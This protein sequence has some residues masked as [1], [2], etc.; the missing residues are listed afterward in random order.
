[1]LFDIF[2]LRG[3]SINHNFV[4][5]YKYNYKSRTTKTLPKIGQKQKACIQPKN[6]FMLTELCSS[7]GHSMN[8]TQKKNH[9]FENMVCMYT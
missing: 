2:P 4:F 8:G 1:M 3:K 6:I 7:T 5:I 9:E